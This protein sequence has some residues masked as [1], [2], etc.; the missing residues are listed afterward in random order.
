M[1]KNIMKKIMIAI[2]GILCLSF[3]SFLDS[4]AF[5]RNQLLSKQIDRGR[6][7]ATTKKNPTI[8][9]V[10]RGH[11]IVQPTPAPVKTAAV[12]WKQLPMAKVE[13]YEI[14]S[15]IKGKRI[16]YQPFH[17][18]QEFRIALKT[19]HFKA[20][21]LMLVQICSHGGQVLDQIM[22]SS[23]DYHTRTKKIAYQ[24]T[25]S[26]LLKDGNYAVAILYH[27]KVRNAIYR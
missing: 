1:V 2:A 16:I 7:Q 10:S 9:M 26:H 20:G 18:A 13:R 3:S 21:F 22:K 24:T 6:G 4:S 23:D 17:G 25:K 11:K 27:A 8:E 19:R 15:G 5:C 12:N 14:K